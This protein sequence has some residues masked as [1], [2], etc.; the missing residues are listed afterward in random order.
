MSDTEMTEEEILKRFKKYGVIITNDH[1]VYNS[2]KHGDTYINKDAIY[3]YTT[4]VS[5]FGKELA[6]MFKRYIIETV[7][8]P[9]KGGIILSQWTAFHLSNLLEW[10]VLSV[11][12]EKNKNNGFFFGRGYDRF[13]KDKRVLIVEDILTTGNSVKKVIELVHNTGGQVIGVG[14]LCNRGNVKAKD[15]DYTISP[16]SLININLKTFSEEE[17]AGYGPCSKGVPINTTVGKGKEFLA[18]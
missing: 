14:A 4:V 11:Y 3:P 7:V 1:F 8:G 17:C 6:G 2:W 10:E 5:E 16:H 13:V 18:R 12:A 9:E 15:I